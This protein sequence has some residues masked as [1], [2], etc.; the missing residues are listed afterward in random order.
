[1]QILGHGELGGRIVA[2]RVNRPAVGAQSAE[3]RNIH[4]DLSAERLDPA[5]VVQP[6]LVGEFGKGPRLLFDRGGKIRID[7]GLQNKV[8]AKSCGEKALHPR[9]VVEH[10]AIEIARVPAQ[11]HVADVEHDDH[12][13]KL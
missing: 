1:M 3:Q 2:E 13:K 10:L 4:F 9:L 7:V 6:D 5:R 8:F 11:K 12:E